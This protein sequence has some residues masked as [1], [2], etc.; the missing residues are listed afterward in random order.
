MGLKL[1]PVLHVAV[2]LIE[3]RGRYLICRRPAGVFLGG[4]WEFPGG[5][6]EKGES[7]T[8]C[9]R[10]ELKEELGIAVRAVKSFHIIRYRYA[11]GM[12]RLQVFRCAIHRGRPRP[13]E[14]SAVRWVTPQQFARYRFPPADR[15]LIRALA[16]STSP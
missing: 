10:R 7:A 2:A 9:L 6:L 4:Y 11:S 16:Q 15:P 1:P 13:L 8:A 3:R 5:K 12:V 14:V